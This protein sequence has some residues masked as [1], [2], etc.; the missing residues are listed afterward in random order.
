MVDEILAGDL[1]IG[2]NRQVPVTGGAPHIVAFALHHHH[3]IRI[4][5]RIRRR[6][7]NHLRIAAV[8]APAQGPMSVRVRGVSFNFD[9]IHPKILAQSQPGHGL[10]DHWRDR[11]H[12]HP[13]QV[14]RQPVQFKQLSRRFHLLHHLFGLVI[15]QQT[16]TYCHH[17]QQ[18]R[19]QHQQAQRR[20]AEEIE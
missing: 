1:F 16:P 20:K 13:E 3:I 6:V 17:K 8:G 2:L 5:H 14:I 18:A 11:A 12:P 10:I 9:D 15:R 4:Q 7:R 19:G